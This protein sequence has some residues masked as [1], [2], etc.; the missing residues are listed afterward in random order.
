[1]RRSESEKDEVGYRPSN[2]SSNEVG[3]QPSRLGRQ[4]FVPKRRMTVSS[5]NHGDY[6]HVDSLAIYL[7]KDSQHA[8][9]CMRTFSMLGYLQLRV[10]HIE[11]QC[12]WQLNLQYQLEGNE[13]TQR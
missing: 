9:R 1:M 10:L 11:H 3:Q 5:I 6:E 12:K 13:D 4:L 8:N 7:Q 2:L